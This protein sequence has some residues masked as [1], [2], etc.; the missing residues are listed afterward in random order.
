M[1]AGVVSDA[2]IAQSHR[3]A[4]DLWTV[5]DSP[6]EW[7]RTPHW[8]QL[9]FDVS[10]PTGE[11]GELAGEIEAERAKRWPQ[12]KA[13]YFGHVADGN[14]HA[15]IGLTDHSVSEVE[16][17]EAIYAITAKRRGSISAEHGIGSLKRPF[18]HFSRSPAELALM[19]AIKQTMDPN[20]I[21]NPG[22][23]L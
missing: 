10:V 2:V 23:V 3:E 19:R 21:L 8:P 4:R 14:L 7:Q 15:S 20:G 18:L 9:G 6:G 13:V 17:E 16:I 5:R 22:K 12:L 1:E 11:I